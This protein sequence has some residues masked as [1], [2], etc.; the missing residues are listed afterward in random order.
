[1]ADP[2]DGPGPPPPPPPPIIFQPNQGLKGRKKFLGD[3]A[4]PFLRVWITPPPPPPY[5]MVWI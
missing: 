3:W 1:M 2:G 5:L 4:P